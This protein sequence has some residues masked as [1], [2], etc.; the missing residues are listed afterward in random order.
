MQVIKSIIGTIAVIFAMQP[1]MSWAATS[2]SSNE[3][4]VTNRNLVIAQPAQNH[5]GAPD[6]F[7]GV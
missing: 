3:P 5:G 4:G 6:C 7:G 2:G 1:L